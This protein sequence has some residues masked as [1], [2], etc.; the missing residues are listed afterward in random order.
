MSKTALA[1][2]SIVALSCGRAEPTAQRQEPN[3]QL[4]CD[5]TSTPRDTD[6]HCV[7]HDTRTGEVKRVAIPSLKVAKVDGPGPEDKAGTYQLACRSTSSNTRS[8]FFCFR[9]HTMT[10][11]LALVPLQSTGVVPEGAVDPL[12]HEHSSGEAHQH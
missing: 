9:L 10:G 5:A 3:Y 6:L 1:L 2:A 8:D 11:E 7:R 12:K 4:V